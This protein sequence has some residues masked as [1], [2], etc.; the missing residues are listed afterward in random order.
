[1][2]RTTWFLVLL[3]YKNTFLLISEAE[4]TVDAA[5][6][7]GSVEEELRCSEAARSIDAGET[8][9]PENGEHQKSQPHTAPQPS[10]ASPPTS[11]LAIY[12]CHDHQNGQE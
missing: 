2:R 6:A 4:N 10:T 5:A 1:M 11:L 7:S 3:S 12:S 8:R 9:S